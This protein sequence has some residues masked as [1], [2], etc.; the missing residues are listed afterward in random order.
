DGSA[1]S[2]RKHE[3]C[4]A[5]HRIVG[6]PFADEFADAEDCCERIIELMRRA[7]KH[8]SHGGEFF[9]LGEL[10][11]HL[12]LFGHVTGGGDN[13]GNAA[14]LVEDGRGAGAKRPPRAVFVRC[15]VFELRFSGQTGNE[16]AEKTLQTLEVVR[17]RA[18]AELLS[19]ELF[20]RVAEHFMSLLADVGEF[21]AAIDDR[22]HVWNAGHQ[23]ADEFLL[24]VQTALDFEALGEVNERALEPNDAAG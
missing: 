17:M 21:S 7:G 2:L 20:G 10:L 6:G 9:A 4:M 8:L 14:I 16:A 22:D 24:F 11:L 5:A 12:N 23:A 3:V 19:N 1:T 13:A 18:A 15:A